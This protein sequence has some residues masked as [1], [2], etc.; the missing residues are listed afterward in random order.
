MSRLDDE[1]RKA[2]RR[3]TPSADFAERVLKAVAAAPVPKRKWWD[4]LLSLLATPKVRLVAVGVAVSLL[5]VLWA[6]QSK[7]VQVPDKTDSR[8]EVEKQVSPG[9]ADKNPAAPNEV[10]NNV[11]EKDQVVPQHP[12]HSPI[13]PRRHV[14][15]RREV[16]KSEGEIA[17]DQL[18]LALHIAGASLYEAQRMVKAGE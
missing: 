3:E 14:S 9:P 17:K 11:T 12:R 5:V 8:A 1:L 2:F 7:R 10:A 4:E 13:K 6:T 15:E 18:M 16:A